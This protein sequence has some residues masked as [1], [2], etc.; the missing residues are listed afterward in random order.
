MLFR[1]VYYTLAVC[2]FE[3]FLCVGLGVRSY[4]SGDLRSR[5]SGRFR[6]RGKN[7]RGLRSRKNNHGGLRKVG[8]P[9]IDPLLALPSAENIQRTNRR[10]S[11]AASFITQDVFGGLYIN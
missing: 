7:E 10:I 5:N 2:R 9:I 4:L 1:R 3:P 11:R 6:S 8:L